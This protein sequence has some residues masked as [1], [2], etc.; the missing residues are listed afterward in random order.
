M[1]A[2]LEFFYPRLSLGG[3]IIMHDYSSAYWDG[4]KLAVDEYLANITDNLI[5]IP[6]KSGHG[7][8]PKGTLII[9]PRLVFIR[10]SK[11]GFIASV[12]VPLS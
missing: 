11:L 7:D 5:L 9:A 6:D 4:A 10:E 2:G 3:L 12:A 8:D 1:K